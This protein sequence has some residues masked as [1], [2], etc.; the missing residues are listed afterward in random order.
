M[1]SS[2]DLIVRKNP[3]L[4]RILS[5]KEGVLK[6]NEAKTFI[7]ETQ[8]HQRVTFIKNKDKEVVGIDY[9]QIDRCA[10]KVTYDSN[11]RIV[12]VALYY[13]D[14]C[15]F[16]VGKFDKD[17]I[18]SFKKGYRTANYMALMKK[19]EYLMA[20]ELDEICEKQN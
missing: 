20:R 1:S 3:R 12:K 10:K 14:K 8:P 15:F 6:K 7:Y 4:T 13:H 17:E 19:Y 11:K 9:E 18:F 2:D 16:G 5:K